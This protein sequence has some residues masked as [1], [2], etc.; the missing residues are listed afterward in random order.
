MSNRYL[1]SHSKKYFSL[2]LSLQQNIWKD[3]IRPIIFFPVV[4]IVILIF[5]SINR[6]AYILCAHYLMWLWSMSR[7]R[8]AAGH[9]DPTSGASFFLWFM[10]SI[11]L[12]L[13]GELLILQCQVTDLLVF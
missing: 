4:Y 5:P 7:L 1:L 11:T 12:T 3:E 8:L 6:F 10:H 2:L 9:S 13:H